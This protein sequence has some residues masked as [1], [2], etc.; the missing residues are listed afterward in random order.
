MQRKQLRKEGFYT[1]LKLQRIPTRFIFFDTETTY[2]KKD[3]HNKKFDLILGCMIYLEI[4][5]ECNTK[6]RNEYTFYSIQEFIDILSI[7]LKDNK[8]IYIFAHNIGFDIRVLN[9][10]RVF[11]D[12]GYTNEP[13]II[14]EMAFIWKVLAGKSRMMFLDTANLGVRSVS[15]L[16]D[17]LKMPKLTIDFDT[18]TKEELTTYC[19]NDVLIL[20]KFV[21]SYVQFLQLHQLGSFKVTL[22]SQSMT[23]YRTKFLQDLPYIHTRSESLVLERSGYH[24]GRV[25]C[26]RIGTFTDQ[27]FYYLDVN[28]MYPHSMCGSL[29]PVKWRGYTTN[30]KIEHIRARLS[31]FYV[32]ARCTI[33]T[34]E[35][36]YSYYR[37]SK[38]IFPIGEFT[39][40]LYHEELEYALKHNHIKYVHECSV[41]DRGVLFDDYVNF[42]YSQKQEYSRTDNYTYRTMSKL[43]LNSLYGKFGQLE[44]HRNLVGKTK[45]NGVW[46]LPVTNRESGKEYQDICWY[47]DIFR[48]FKEG[49]TALSCPAIAGAITCRAR[50][51]LWNFMCYAGK[52][53]VY[54]VDT[55]SLI[56]NKEGYD[57][58]KPYIDKDKL[59]YLKLEDESNYLEIHGNKDYSF[60][61]KSKI[62][63]VPKSATV[64][65]KNTWE[66]LQFEGFISWLN[67]GAEGSPSGKYTIKR[68]I[69]NYNKGVVQPNGIVT[70]FILTAGV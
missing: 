55:D 11:A 51:F 41:Y 56:V 2:P 25:E 17:D 36:V 24:G 21:L 3:N 54:Y 62:K 10:P 37:D 35:P 47:G 15:S 23:T 44:P 69:T 68:R 67:N 39:T 4:D 59:G 34:G 52:E 64:L 27:N 57:R 63:G 9:L 16:G 19:L 48:E 65:D 28:S 32:I 8:M 42:F 7:Y 46:R 5:E 49:E 60:G 18:C 6:I 58:L 29:N 50:M 26:F 33:D 30:V 13:P 45:Y 1:P 43:F 40:V 66:Y 61:S 12:M 22:A 70:P 38:L 31:R 53:N 20:E 14:N